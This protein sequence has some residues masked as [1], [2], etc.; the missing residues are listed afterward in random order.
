MSEIIFMN[1]VPAFKNLVWDLVDALAAQDVV[2]MDR[3]EA[4]V[5]VALDVVDCLPL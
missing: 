4:A 1:N 5:D 2:A 3:P